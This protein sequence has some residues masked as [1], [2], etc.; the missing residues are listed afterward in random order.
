M[1][2]FGGLKFNAKKDKG[3]VEHGGNP[4]NE[5]SYLTSTTI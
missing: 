3:Y 2:G 5:P 4:K 1:F